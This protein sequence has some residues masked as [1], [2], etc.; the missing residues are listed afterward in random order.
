MAQNPI[1]SCIKIEV[2]QLSL[3]T[4]NNDDYCLGHSW[5]SE[6]SLQRFR[7]HLIGSIFLNKQVLCEKDLKNLI[8]K[9]WSHFHNVYVKNNW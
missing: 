2:Q 7:K 4:M 9:F 5:W 1:K 6:E 3:D 8:L